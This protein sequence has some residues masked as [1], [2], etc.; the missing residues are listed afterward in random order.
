MPVPSSSPPSP[1]FS[2][3]Y[4]SLSPVSLSLRRSSSSIT[5][6]A[7]VIDHLRGGRAWEPPQSPLPSSTS[8][9]SQREGSGAIIIVCDPIHGRRVRD[10]PLSLTF[11]RPQWEGSGAAIVLD[12]F[13]GRR[14]REP[15]PPSS[16]T[17]S[18]TIDN[19]PFMT[20]SSISRYTEPVFWKCL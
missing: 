6:A 20:I 10:L 2:F 18:M 12:P 16:S 14:T 9:H 1:S 15:P 4:P 8:S 13:R 11:S 5:I 17:P 19:K 7:T 3:P